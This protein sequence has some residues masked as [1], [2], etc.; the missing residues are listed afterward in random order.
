MGR[1]IRIA[2]L[3]ALLLAALPPRAGAAAGAAGVAVAVQAGTAALADFNGDGIDDLAVGVPLE[4][5]GGTANAGVVD[6][7]YGSESGLADG[8]REQLTQAVPEPGDA[9]G[10]AVAT[11][12]Y[13]GDLFTDLA[14]GVPGEN[15][16]A[17]AD[18]G[19]VEVFYGTG[20]GGLPSVGDQLL[21]QGANGMAGTAEAGDRFGAALASGLVD[22]GDEADL[23]VGAPNE[24]VGATADAG[25]VSLVDGAA[26][27]LLGSANQLIVETTPETGDR[28]G[29]AVEIGDLSGGGGTAGPDDLAIGAPS[30]NV[31]STVDAG[32]V[33]L[34]DAADDGSGLGGVQERFFQGD[35]GVPGASETGDRFGAAL[36]GGLFGSGGID[37]AVGVPGEDVGS[38]GD[39]GAVVVLVGPTL[40]QLFTQGGAT[41]G[42]SVPGASESGDQ[43][44]AALGTGDFDGNSADNLVIGAPGEDL[45][46]VADAGAVISLCGSEGLLSGCPDGVLTQGNPETGDGYGASLTPGNFDGSELPDLAAG[47]PGETVAGAVSAGAAD[48]RDG[49]LGGLPADPDEPLYFQGND[50]VPGTAEAGDLFAAALSA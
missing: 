35:S 18:A 13:N 1:T 6:I 38:A 14:V 46:T 16:G 43:F 26:G 31:G 36:A 30:E 33:T 8:A 5:L 49:D 22:D 15:V 4:D 44:G 39:A 19:A 47:A 24:D 27:G 29:A 7:V 12:D 9:F 20:L 37:L 3:A 28:F 10:S 11:G 23:A 17:T 40:H 21:R 2:V 42:G 50:G 32:A 34:I 45:G 25:A 41:T 48:A